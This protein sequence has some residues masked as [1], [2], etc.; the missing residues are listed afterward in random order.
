M[1]FAAS[2][3]FL[4][5]SLLRLYNRMEKIREFATGKTMLLA[6]LLLLPMLSVAYAENRAVTPYGDYCKE[7]SV[8]GVCRRVI[9]P[10]EA[11]SALH[12]YYRAKGCR[13]L[14]LLQRGRFIVAEIYRRHRQVDK[15]IFDRKTGRL[16]SIY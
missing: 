10:D 8:Y 6:A 12:N 14:I 7:Y 16:R 9:P 4:H 5:E 2:S 3:Y 11:V 1:I 15:V 13:V